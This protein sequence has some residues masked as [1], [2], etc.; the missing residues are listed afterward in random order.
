MEEEDEN[1][2]TRLEIIKLMYSKRRAHTC[3]TIPKMTKNSV[4]FNETMR[5]VV[6]ERLA[7]SP[8][9]RCKLWYTLGEIRQLRL[10]HPEVNSEEI[11]ASRRQ[12]IS[13]VLARQEQHKKTR[14]DTSS[15][16]IVRSLMTPSYDE[17]VSAKD[18][19][20]TCQI[21][22]RKDRQKARREAIAT[23]N[24]VGS[25]STTSTTT[26][27]GGK[28]GVKMVSMMSLLSG[29]KKKASIVHAMKEE[30]T[31]QYDSMS[32]L[33]MTNTIQVCN[34]IEGCL[35]SSRRLYIL[36]NNKPQK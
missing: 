18:L 12:T 36:N 34:R 27:R 33:V 16:I 2:R 14:D 6:V 10:D 23:A 35:T 32:D 30:W 21:Q 28:Q 8:T 29:G 19:A 7:T 13:T 31:Y 11:R 1:K 15:S 25:S 22:T 9:E 17:D 26:K 3:N 5:L 24:F 20:R 4:S